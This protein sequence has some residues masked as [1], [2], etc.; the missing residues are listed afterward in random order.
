MSDI[1][2]NEGE[3]LD[4]V[5]EKIQLISKVDGLTFG[6]DAFLLASFIREQKRAKA[7]ELGTG[8]GIIP[9][10]LSARERVKE[11]YAFEVQEDFSELALRNAALNGFEEKI[12]II[13]ADVRNIKSLD[14]DGECDIVFTNPPY[15]G[16]DNGKRNASD[17]KYIARHEVMGG[18]FD[19]CA[20]ADRLLKHGGKFYCVWRPDRLSELF[21]AMRENHMEPKA[22]VFVHADI[23][24][25]PSTVLISATKGGAPSM[26][27]M[28]PLLLHDT[29]VCENRSRVLSPKAQKIYDEMSFYN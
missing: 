19:F 29:R 6:T 17:R 4:R 16:K 18:I 5:N 21:A 1:I 22:A 23:E 11:I 20:A 24:S 13:N 26:R 27:I 10:L 2:P 9:L 7:A 28:P 3:R 25:E 8:T 14:T 15:M 12:K